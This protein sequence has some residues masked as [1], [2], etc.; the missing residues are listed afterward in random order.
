MATVDVFERPARTAAAITVRLTDEERAKLARF[1]Y[2]HDLSQAQ[3]FRRML[4]QLPD[5]ED[6]K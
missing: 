3:A 4:R 6:K 5:G 1:A 2:Q